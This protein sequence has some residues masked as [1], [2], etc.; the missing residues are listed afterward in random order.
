[1]D[2]RKSCKSHSDNKHLPHKAMALENKGKI[3]PE[4]FHEGARLE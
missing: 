2:D 1:M 4:A 3:S